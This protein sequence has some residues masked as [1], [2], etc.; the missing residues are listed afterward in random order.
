M[1]TTCLSAAL[2]GGS[3]SSPSAS[4]LPWGRYS[5]AKCTPSRSRPGSGRSRATGVPMAR[6]TGAYS[7]RSPPGPSPLRLG[8]QRVL[9]RPADV[10]VGDEPGALGAHLVQPPVQVALLH[11]ELGDAVAEQAADPAVPPVAGPLVPGGGQLRGGGRPGGP[12]PDDGDLPAGQ[13]R[14]RL[15]GHPAVDERLV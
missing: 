13:L 12:G 6:T 10:H 15:R 4:R 9:P 5:M 2:I 7:P 8:A 1:I 11:L 3:S 14:G